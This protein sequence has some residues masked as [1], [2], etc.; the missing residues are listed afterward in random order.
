MNGIGKVRYKSKT[1]YTKV[2]KHPQNTGI[3]YEALGSKFTYHNSVLVMFH[4]IKCAA[5]RN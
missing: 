2:S 5:P 4:K 3:L 1:S